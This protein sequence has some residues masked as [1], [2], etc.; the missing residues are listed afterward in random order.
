MFSSSTSDQSN[1]PSGTP[2][3]TSHPNNSSS[4]TPFS[5]SHQN[6]SSS[7]TSLSS[8][9]R[10]N[11]SSGTLFNPPQQNNS[12]SGT[13]FSPFQR[14]NSSSGTPLSSS[15]QDS[16]SSGISSNSSFSSHD[17]SHQ[18][19]STHNDHR[20]SQNTP[21]EPGYPKTECYSNRSFMPTQNGFH[22]SVN[23]GRNYEARYEKPDY[24]KG[25]RDP[26]EGL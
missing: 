22:W 17:N 23:K 1:R 20:Q 15:Q 3:D 26:F 11:S 16:R 14:N 4:S 12:S 24:M 6:N 7:G 8:S 10:N 2:F 9:Q 5:S 25:T 19:G 21:F 13:L 18:F